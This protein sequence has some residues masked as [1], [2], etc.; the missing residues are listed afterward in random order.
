MMKAMLPALDN[1]VQ[2]G[3]APK[4]NGSSSVVSLGKATALE[5]AEFWDWFANEGAAKGQDHLKRL[6][7]SEFV[8]II[9]EIMESCRSDLKLLA[10]DG[11]R[12][13]RLLAL[14]AIVPVAEQVEMA[15]RVNLPLAA[16][17]RD[18]KAETAAAEEFQERAQPGRCRLRSCY[19]LS[20][21]S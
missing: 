4:N 7:D 18:V 10:S 17:P 6:I 9:K 16:K 8:I 3:M 21:T 5:T 2:F 11:I 13:L 14:G 12:R 1:V 15:V 20:L 19:R